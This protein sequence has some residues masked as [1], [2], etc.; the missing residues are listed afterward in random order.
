LKDLR[1]ARSVRAEYL[2]VVSEPDPVASRVAERWGTPPSV[3][4]HVEGAPVRRLGSLALLLRR[5][6]P[7]VHDER[8]DERLP[9]ELRAANV[10]LV[11]PSIHRS[12]RDIQCLT[13]HPLGNL[14]P[15]A[16][17]GGRPRTVDPTDPRRMAATLRRLSAE[18]P[19]L[20]LSATF[21]ATHHG[22]ELALPAF[23][24]EIGY[25]S[26]P[27]PPEGAVDL[28][29]R[30][31]PELTSDPRDRVAVGIGGGHYVPHFTEL[32]L[33]RMWA[34]GHLVSRH[35]LAELDAATARSAFE[36]TPGA[37]GI[38]FARAEDARHPALEGLGVRLRDADASPRDAAR[39]TAD[40]G[41]A[42]ET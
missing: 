2:V 10:T 9:S 14:G 37:E 24:V 17:V 38:V 23:F 39:S 29:A 40:A 27:A 4:L 8:L 21:E 20:G 32:A 31:L 16:E 3:G 13:V 42:S 35:A 41:P 22:P 7:H 30:V 15:T 19:S 25:G 34:F 1:V 26:E 5:P 28:L 18:A 12:E 36:R 11:F 33:R 6:G